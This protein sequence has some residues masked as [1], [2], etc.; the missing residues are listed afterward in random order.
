[1]RVE[2]PTVPVAPVRGDP[3]ALPDGETRVGIVTGWYWPLGTPEPVHFDV[4]DADGAKRRIVRLRDADGRAWSV[5][6]REP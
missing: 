6:R 1:M 2:A 5:E 3:I 4:Q